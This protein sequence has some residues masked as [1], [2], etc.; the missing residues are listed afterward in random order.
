MTE[1][2]DLRT[3]CKSCP[4]CEGNSFTAIDSSMTS[5]CDEYES[6]C[7][8]VRCQNCKAEGPRASSSECEKGNSRFCNISRP[9]SGRVYE[10]MVIARAYTG[11]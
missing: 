8:W 3:R 7:C 1:E 10:R 2:E 9:C 5:S 4:F 11:R 6:V